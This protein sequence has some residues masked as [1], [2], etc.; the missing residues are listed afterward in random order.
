[1]RK[2]FVILLAISAFSFEIAH[3]AKRR[4]VPQARPLVLQRGA[5]MTFFSNTEGTGGHLGA[6][7][8]VDLSR[9]TLDIY[10]VLRQPDGQIRKL[11][12]YDAMRACP[13]GS[14]LVSFR[15]AAA[16]FQVL[17]AKIT[18]YPASTLAASEIKPE[19]R[20]RGFVTV[21]PF[22]NATAKRD[23]FTGDKRDNLWIDMSGYRQPQETLANTENF[24]LSSLPPHLPY[25]ALFSRFDGKRFGHY[26]KRTGKAAVRCKAN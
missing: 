9:D 26:A 23:F 11:N 12:H 4:S 18:E 16:E 19:D 10:G 2:L 15:E 6:A 22:I 13:E 25:T 21:D 5:G 1:M 24:W 7:T 8:T 17:G 3:A 20:P 14:H